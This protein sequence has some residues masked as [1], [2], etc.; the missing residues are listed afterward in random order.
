[1]LTSVYIRLCNFRGDLRVQG[2]KCQSTRPRGRLGP[3]T[4]AAAAATFSVRRCKLGGSLGNPGGLLLAKA[5][6]LK[7]SASL[8]G[9]GSLGVLGG[10]GRFR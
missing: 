5:A 9:L 8:C 2:Q 10:M 6:L 3:S 7:I 4:G 1:M